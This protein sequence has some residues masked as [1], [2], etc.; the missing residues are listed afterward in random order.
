MAERYL[1][2]LKPL[3]PYAFGTDQNFAYSGETPTGKESYLVTS[4]TTPPQTTVLGTLRYILLSWSG[5]LKE[6]FSYTAAE[7]ADMAR[8][9]GPETF[10]FDKADQDFG[11]IRAL[12]PVFLADL[13]TEGRDA[14]AT[15][16][17]LVPNPYCNTFPRDGGS[18]YRPM[19]MEA[20][21]TRTS[22]GAISMPC[23]GEYDVKDYHPFGYLRIEPPAAADATPTLLR[24]ETNGNWD[25][26][27]A[28]TFVPGIRV[29]THA[30]DDQAL[31]R[32]ELVTLERGYAFAF[33]LDYDDPT[34]LLPS[35]DGRRDV[36]LMGKGRSPFEVRAVATA[37]DLDAYVEGAFAAAAPAGDGQRPWVMALSDF[38]VPR[39]ADGDSGWRLDTFSVVEMSHQRGL[40]T[41]Y[42]AKSSMRKLRKEEVRRHLISAGSAFYG[43]LPSTLAFDD[44]HLR[45]A[46]YNHTVILGKGTDR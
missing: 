15:P 39:A 17:I 28:S 10:D 16:A 30:D 12:S 3:G 19:R 43:H 9:I 23:Q 2:T 14:A 45:R 8:L 21:P 4:N 32:R 44:E 34:G 11:A 40:K 6:S 1:V 7:R 33:T 20:T 42:D 13:G 36:V 18:A 37:F 26:P 29:G 24:P 5:L 46:G 35:L 41:V 22:H 25:F 31:F 27:F 38:Y